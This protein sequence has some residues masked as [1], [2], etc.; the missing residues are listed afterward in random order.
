MSGVYESKLTT[1]NPKTYDLK[2]A[3]AQL[4][5]I[6]RDAQT[7]QSSLLTMHGVPVAALVSVE[8]WQQTP[9]EVSSHAGILA[10]RG[11]GRGLWGT[12]AATNVRKLR[13]EWGN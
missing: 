9:T 10:L 7:G 5:R 8:Q 13:G 6:V 3:A 12:S 11:T 2:K 1:M 4:S